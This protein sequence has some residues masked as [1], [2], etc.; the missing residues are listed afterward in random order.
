MKSGLQNETR[1]VPQG[2]ILGP[3]LFLRY[4]NAVC[5]ISNMPDF[6]VYADVINIFANIEILI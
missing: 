5:N 6:T 1:G 2:S 3:K 4:I